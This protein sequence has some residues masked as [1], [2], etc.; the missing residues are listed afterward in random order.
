MKHRP[1]GRPSLEKIIRDIKR[2][3]RK[4]YRAEEKNSHRTGGASRRKQ[5]RGAVPPRRYCQ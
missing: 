1:T 5:H 4:Q 3:T 2:K